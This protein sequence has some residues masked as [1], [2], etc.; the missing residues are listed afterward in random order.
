MAKRRGLDI[1]TL[2]GNTGIVR[3]LYERNGTRELELV[4]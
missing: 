4:T 3:A 1:Y 2:A